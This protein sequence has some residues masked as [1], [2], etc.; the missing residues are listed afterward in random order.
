MCY[1]RIWGSLIDI[2]YFNI[3]T[4]GGGQPAAI[5]NEKLK[6]LNMFVCTNN[7]LIS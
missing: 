3:V 4:S 1:S 5:S 6:K 2:Y 7:E